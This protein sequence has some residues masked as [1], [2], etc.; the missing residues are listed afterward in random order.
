MKSGAKQNGGLFREEVIEK[1]FLARK[2]ARFS[3]V[4]LSGR[5]NFHKNG[6]S[7]YV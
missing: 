4:I 7:S 2:C 3:S 6:R 1:I 5:R